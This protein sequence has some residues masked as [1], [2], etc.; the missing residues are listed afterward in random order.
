MR[1]RGRRDHPRHADRY[2]REQCTR[3]VD[4]IARRAV[5]ELISKR[6]R[7]G[8]T[9]PDLA[10]PLQAMQPVGEIARNGTLN[11]PH[12]SQIF[13]AE[14]GMTPSEYRQRALRLP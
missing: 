10:D 1:I 2:A 12:F 4:R 7:R 8:W 13:R 11:A 3:Q 6:P 14:Y 9:G 5:V